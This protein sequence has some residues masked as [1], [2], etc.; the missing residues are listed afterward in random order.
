METVCAKCKGLLEK[1]K[2]KRWFGNKCQ[3]CQHE[4]ELERDRKRRLARKLK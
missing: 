4:E 3:K 1:P 2:I